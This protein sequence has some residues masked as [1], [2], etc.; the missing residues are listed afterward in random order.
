MSNLRHHP[1]SHALLFAPKGSSKARPSSLKGEGITIASTPP[2]GF[3]NGPAKT[4]PSNSKTT[5]SPPFNGRRR[6]VFELIPEI[7]AS[8]IERPSDARH[9]VIPKGVRASLQRLKRLNVR[10]LGLAIFPSL[11]DIYDLPTAEW[12]AVKIE[13]LSSSQR[14][15]SLQ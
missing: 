6:S 8:N 2:F 13:K 5:S 14:S 1:K 3:G 12:L 9:T 10:G 11:I 15:K 4:A 7:R